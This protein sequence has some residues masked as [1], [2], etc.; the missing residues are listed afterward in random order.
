MPVKTKINFNFTRITKDVKKQFAT[1]MNGRD[2]EIVLGKIKGLIAKGVSPVF[3]IGRLQKYSE[4]YILTMKGLIDFRTSK[5]GKTLKSGEGFQRT[6]YPIFPEDGGKL[7]TTAT[8]YGK[9]PRP[10]NLYLSGEMMDSLTIT[11]N[12]L[13][14]VVR[15]L[16]KKAIYH[17]ELGA[18]R[19]K[20]LRRVL[21]TNPG[22]FFHRTVQKEIASLVAK[23][24]RLST[25]K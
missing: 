14:P 8:R 1:L 13:N 6:I 11:L 21:P 23:S 20:T 18:G 7:E 25:Q 22:E 4:S 19:S 2:G 17:N 3:G 24:I 9:K 12:G 10:V 15:F 5:S 16:D